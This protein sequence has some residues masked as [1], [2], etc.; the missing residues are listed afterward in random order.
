MDGTS[1]QQPTVDGGSAG[2][3]A[4]RASVYFVKCEDFIKIGMTHNVK[5]RMCALSTSNPFPLTCIGT[6]PGGKAFEAWLHARFQ[7]ERQSG[8]WFHFRGAVA[9]FVREC[10]TPRSAA[11]QRKNLVAWRSD[12][13]CDLCGGR[14]RHVAGAHES[15]MQSRVPF[16]ICRSCDAAWEADGPPRRLAA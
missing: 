15:D 3:R 14:L 16:L 12:S 13:P 1:Q 5:G 11:I 6:L 9:A 4:T 8:E 10:V 2:E 7:C